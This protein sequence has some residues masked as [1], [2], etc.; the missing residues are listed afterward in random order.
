M[1]CLN[2]PSLASAGLTNP[3]GAVTLETTTDERHTVSD[4]TP[5]GDTPPVPPAPPAYPVPPTYGQATEAAAPVYGQP[6][7]PTAPVADSYGQASATPPAYPQAPQY[8][9]QPY[10]Q[11]PYGQ[12]SAAYGQ[13]PSAPYGQAQAPYGQA[14]SPYGQAAPAYAQ[15][16]GYAAAPKTNSLAIV[17][18]V[19]SIA[20]WVIV[21]LIASIVGVI[22]GHMALKQLRSS[23]EGGRGLALAGTIVGWVGVAFWALIVIIIIVVISIAIGETARYGAY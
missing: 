16:Y 2:R 9:Q 5:Q 14:Q 21:P 11:A 19:A 4:T 8:G 17:S 22:T 20:G 7:E 23:G 12:A 6:A 3:G 1:W 13:A 10:G 15:G 18:L